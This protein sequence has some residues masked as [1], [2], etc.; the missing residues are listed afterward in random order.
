MR[1]CWDV[2]QCGQQPKSGSIEA[3]CIVPKLQEAVCWLVAGAHA[4]KE[5]QCLEVKHGKEC[6]ACEYYKVFH[7]ELGAFMTEK[8]VNTVKHSWTCLLDHH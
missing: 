3:R 4:P 2:M 6:D 5:M 1:K 8:E 7:A